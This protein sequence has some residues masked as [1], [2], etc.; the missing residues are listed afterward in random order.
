MIEEAST[1]GQAMPVVGPF[2]SLSKKA[3]TPTRYG[4]G[5]LA[6][7]PLSLLPQRLM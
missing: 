5:I 3:H 4:I 7:R 2:R 1:N 6:H